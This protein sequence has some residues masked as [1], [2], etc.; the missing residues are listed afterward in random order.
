MRLYIYVNELVASDITITE[1]ED[2]DL[3]GDGYREIILESDS[4]INVLSDGSGIDETEE[5]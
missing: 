4:P 5:Y 1:E 3:I 2:I